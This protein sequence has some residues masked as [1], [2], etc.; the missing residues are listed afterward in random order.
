MK[1]RVTVVFELSGTEDFHKFWTK[2]QSVHANITPVGGGVGDYQHLMLMYAAY[3]QFVA[4][5][6]TDANLDPMVLVSTTGEHFWKSVNGMYANSQSFFSATEIYID[7]DTLEAAV[8][9]CVVPSSP[10]TP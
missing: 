6:Q 8:G 7:R 4:S 3:G 9:A 5:G 10:H 2:V 1:K